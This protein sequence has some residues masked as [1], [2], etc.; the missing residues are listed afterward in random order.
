[1]KEAEKEQRE[2][3]WYLI[4]KCENAKYAVLNEIKRV[5]AKGKKKRKE[6]DDLK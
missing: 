4:D 5:H 2:E 6:A 1:M 3:A